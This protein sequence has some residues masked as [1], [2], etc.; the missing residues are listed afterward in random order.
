MATCFLFVAIPLA[1][2]DHASAHELLPKNV[3]QYIKENP[4]AS[5]EQIKD[6]IE[7]N[8]PEIAGRVK[9]QQ[10]VIEIVNQDTSFIDNALDFI[11][12]GIHHILSGLDHILFVLSLLLVAVGLAQVLKYTATFTLAHSLT[13]ILA[14]SGVLTLSSR[15]VEPIIAL[16]IAAVALS[17]VFLRDNKYFGNIKYKLGIIFAF[18]L[19]HGLGFA[20]L[21][22]EIQ[23]PDD[24]FISS[25][26]A[27]N[28]GIEIGQ[29]MFV[30]VAF[31]LL[32]L[33]RKKSWYEVFIKVL[34]VLISIIAIF[35]MFQRIFQ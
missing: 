31:P 9:D 1:V 25:L 29:I 27:F 34:A 13:I 10:D 7:K 3:I 2:P 17:T 20:G 11:K 8:A 6:Y 14:G 23:I 16:S 4:E 19:F 21:L 5:E 33:L 22:E 35:W 32:Y 18:G 24:K 30:A 28:I 15:I 26:V 12:L